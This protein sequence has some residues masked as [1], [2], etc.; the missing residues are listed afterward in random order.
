M[1][2][3]VI[4]PLTDYHVTAVRACLARAARWTG[5]EGVPGA[6]E[7]QEIYDSFL[8]QE[9][10][11]PDFINTLGIAFGQILVD[12]GAMEWVRV[13]DQQ[14][15]EVCVAVR[16]VECFCAPISMM[17]KR[18]ARAESLSIEQLCTDTLELLRRQSQKQGVGRR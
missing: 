10:K 14:G 3:P 7:V 4:A 18:V 15:E 5:V 9:I 16:G 1:D 6:D 17:E 13:N 2:A 11:Y 12:R 8:E